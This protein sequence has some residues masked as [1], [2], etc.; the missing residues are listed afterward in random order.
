MTR[1]NVLLGLF[2][3]LESATFVLNHEIFNIALS[4]LKA[5][6]AE[7]FQEFTFEH[8]PVFDCPEI[9]DFWE[10]FRSLQPEFISVKEQAGEATEF[11]IKGE[12][13]QPYVDMFNADQKEQL[14][15]A[16]GMLNR[17]LLG[18]QAPGLSIAIPIHSTP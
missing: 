13:I 7:L 6:F 18:V 15:T 5:K 9:P 17:M 3:F 4:Q 2:Y 8:N 11:W 14:R 1:K 12:N 16:A 10:L